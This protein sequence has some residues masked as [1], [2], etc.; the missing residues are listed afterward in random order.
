MAGSTFPLF[1]PAMYKRLGVAWG[2]GLLAGT[3]MLLRLLAPLVL[4]RYGEWIRKKS[5]YCAG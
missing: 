2:N 5:A 4:W 1:A 3:A